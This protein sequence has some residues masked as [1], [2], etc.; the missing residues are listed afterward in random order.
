MNS[1]L[2]SRDQLLLYVSSPLPFS[3]GYWESVASGLA[4]R[5]GIET[6]VLVDC[7]EYPSSAER[8][9]RTAAAFNRRSKMTVYG[10]NELPVQWETYWQRVRNSGCQRLAVV[11]V[12]QAERLEAVVRETIAWESADMAKPGDGWGPAVEQSEL[13]GSSSPQVFW[14]PRW[15]AGDWA[16]VLGAIQIPE[17][18]VVASLMPGQSLRHPTNISSPWTFQL[19]VP[20]PPPVDP[21]TEDRSRS[22]GEIVRK[23]RAQVA[24][25]IWEM[26]RRGVAADFVFETDVI[27]SSV[28]QEVTHGGSLSKQA[29][30]DKA[31][32]PAQRSL[33]RSWDLYQTRYESP[34]SLD[35]GMNGPLPFPSSEDLRNRLNIQIPWGAAS[36]HPCVLDFGSRHES[37]P[38]QQACHLDVLI[39]P[40]EIVSILIGKALVAFEPEREVCVARASS[41]ADTNTGYDAE[42]GASTRMAK[43]I[44]TGMASHLNAMMDWIPS[45]YRIA[46]SAVDPNSMGSAAIDSD[47]FEQVRWGEVWTTFCAFALAGGPP[48]RGTLLVPELLSGPG[49]PRSGDSNGVDLERYQSVVAEIRRGIQECSGLETQTSVHH[50]WV[51]VICDSQEMAGWMLLAIVAENV[52]ARREESV[53]YVPAGSQFRVRREIKNVIAAIAKTAYYW[54]QYKQDR[55]MRQT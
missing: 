23:T 4:G 37:S 50:G 15:D 52:M 49:E 33:D 7:V 55:L 17:R 53:L 43:E 26:R 24:E 1:S 27:P 36:V 10:S 48:H 12:G 54:R 9:S 28:H 13:R 34:N 30:A 40:C 18:N 16:D 47:A 5:I 42:A 8:T 46:E 25:V 41:L 45:H 22:V 11:S 21:I 14:G 32:R 20:T 29:T 3:G 35:S 2:D 39:A 19:V 38:N 6:C 44:A 51:G 31:G